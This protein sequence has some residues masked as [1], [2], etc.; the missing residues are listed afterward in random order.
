MAVKIYDKY[1]ADV[2]V[3][4]GVRSCMSRN[5]KLLDKGFAVIHKMADSICKKENNPL[6]ASDRLRLAFADLYGYYPIKEPDRLDKITDHFIE[7]TPQ[8]ERR[9]QSSLHYNI[10]TRGL[11]TEKAKVQTEILWSSFLAM[12]DNAFG[13]A[14]LRSFAEIYADKKAQR[15]EELQNA[16]LM[17]VKNK[18]KRNDKKQTNEPEQITIPNS[19]KY[20]LIYAGPRKPSPEQFRPV[21]RRQPR[22][23]GFEDPKPEG[24][25][26]TSFA[27]KEDINVGEWQLYCDKEMPSWNEY[28]LRGSWHIVP[29]ED[30]RILEFKKL[31]DIR[32]YIRTSRN[33]RSKCSDFELEQ[34]VRDYWS[35]AGNPLFIDYAAM[36]KDYDVFVFPENAGGR[37]PLFGDWT[38]SGFVMNLDKVK[39]MEND[40]YAQ[41][42]KDELQKFSA[43][44]TN[45]YELD[46]LK[47]GGNTE[48]NKQMMQMLKMAHEINKN[49]K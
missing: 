9:H 29:T 36:S 33:P 41:F 31:D 23:Y 1:L 13:K 6:A 38:R 16:A 42:R 35:D 24:G 45:S 25:L 2:D 22:C 15:E 43:K 40:E 27:S 44:I 34:G 8:M 30:C 46:K 17:K 21:R 32:P 26:W 7:F 18:I 12:E 19:L 4:D 49:R 10:T 47:E 28:K 11:Q 39:V 48:H 3:I 5:D 14:D 37:D 20:P